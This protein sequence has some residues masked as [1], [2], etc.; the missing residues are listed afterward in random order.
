[1]AAF[2]SGCGR[3]ASFAADAGICTATTRIMKNNAI[4][5]MKNLLL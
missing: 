3:F 4:H 5:R 2:C 1:M